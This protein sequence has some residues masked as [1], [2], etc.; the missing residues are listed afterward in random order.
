M[1]K[2]YTSTIKHNVTAKY[3]MVKV[4][5]LLALF[6]SALFLSHIGCNDKI[7]HIGESVV[8]SGDSSGDD[9]QIER[10]DKADRW[11]EVI[12]SLGDEEVVVARI[13]LG[14]LRG[15]SI[16][17]EDEF[18]GEFDVVQDDQDSDIEGELREGLKG[19]FTAR[20]LTALGES[21]VLR[22]DRYVANGDIDAKKL[23]E[24]FTGSMKICL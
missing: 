21:G 18:L 20:M 12:P 10:T 19:T 7:D 17:V 16:E 15:E 11:R 1:R 13:K 2:D 8:L 6:N 4:Y 24:G 5:S 14:E 23:V 9:Q 3:R 22:K